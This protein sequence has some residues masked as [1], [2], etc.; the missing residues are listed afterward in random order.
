MARFRIVTPAGASFSTAGGGYAYEMEALE[1]LDV[2][3]VEGNE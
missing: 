3:I 1:G 2:E